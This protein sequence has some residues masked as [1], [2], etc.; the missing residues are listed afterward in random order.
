MAEI[1][2]WLGSA[3]IAN[4]PMTLAAEIAQAGERP[5]VATSAKIRPPKPATSALTLGSE[6]G[7]RR[8]GLLGLPGS[9]VTRAWLHA[10]LNTRP[11]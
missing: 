5:Q 2:E 11:R 1:G 3:R 4:D 8:R 10:V 7:G 9:M 6:A